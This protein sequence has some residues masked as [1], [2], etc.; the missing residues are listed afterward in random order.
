MLVLAGFCVWR[1]IDGYAITSAV[2]P[3]GPSN[4]LAKTVARQT[5]GW[6]ANYKT[7]PWTMAA[8]IVAI[9]ALLIISPLLSKRREGLAFLASGL[10]V[11]GIIATAGLALFPFLLPSSIEPNASL[12]VWDASSSQLRLS[13]R[14]RRM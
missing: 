7:Y 14:S 12:T 2:V 4:P 11:A 13:T 8:P 1:W 5:G 3:D 6:L 9:G 10:G